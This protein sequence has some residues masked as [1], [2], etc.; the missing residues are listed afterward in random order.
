MSAGL[1]LG[2]EGTSAV[3]LGTG[4]AI[5]RAC[6]A[7]LAAAGANVAC[8][9][10]DPE[11]AKASAESAAAAGVQSLAIETDVLRRESIRA[12]FGQAVERFGRL[13]VLVNVVGGSLWSLSADTTDEEWDRGIA[14]NLRHQWVAAQEALA[15]MVPA[16]SG[17]IVM[18]A[19]VSGLSASTNHGSYGAA[20]AGVINLARTLAVENGRHGIRVNAVAPGSIDTPARAGDD[21]LAGKVPLGRRGHPSDIGNAAVFL[22]SKAAAYI[23][24]QTLVVDGGVTV[25]HTLIDLP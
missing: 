24:G 17:S 21:A 3:V 2:L 10:I 25:K 8:L 1:E 12:G 7:G 5:G 23:T 11:A 20:K 14:I 16:G 18:I 22:S 6:V 4:P 19:S 13:D 15:H 9:D